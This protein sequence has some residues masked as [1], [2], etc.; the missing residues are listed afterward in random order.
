MPG[1]GPRGGVGQGRSGKIHFKDSWLDQLDKNGDS[2]RLYVQKTSVFTFKCI[3]CLS[4][5]LAVDNI[6]KTA[7]FQHAGSK[8]HR[9]V[10]GLRSGRVKDQV[11]FDGKEPEHDIN[12][13]ENGEV[14]NNNP[15]L[16]ADRLQVVGGGI[17]SFFKPMMRGPA[18]V[19]NPEKKMSLETKSN[20]AVIKIA[21]KAVQSNWSYNSLDTFPEFLADIAPDSQILQKIKLKSSKLSYV[22]SHGLGPHFHDILMDDLKNA[23]CYTLGLDAA[24]TKQL[25]LTKS[26][27]FKLRF[28][29]GRLGMVGLIR[30]FKSFYLQISFRLLTCSL[31]VT[32]LVMKLPIS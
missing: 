5:D 29:S 19:P 1:Q 26:L 21:L 24:T 10:A 6:G 16:V 32:T 15:E 9:F 12:D 17:K 3:W 25:G 7:I 27:D 20:R 28:F 14:E 2:P 4:G 8:N 23:P 11:V 30:S 22:I 18:V 13:P 31:T